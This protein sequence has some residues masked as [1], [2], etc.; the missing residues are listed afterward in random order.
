MVLFRSVLTVYS[1]EHE[2][3]WLPNNKAECAK[4]EM[5]DEIRDLIRDE[6]GYDSEDEVDDDFVVEMKWQSVRKPVFPP[7]SFKDVDYTPKPNE[8]LAEVYRETG[9]Q[10]IVKLA[11]IELTPENPDFPVGGW[12]V[13][14][15]MNEHICG[16]ALYYLDSENITSSNLSFRMQT[17]DL[18]ESDYYMVGQQ[19]FTWLEGVHGTSLQ[20]GDC[21]CL[22][23]YGQVETRQGR[24]LAFP[25]VL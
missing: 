8:R 18:S 11:S 25:N 15:Q 20:G 21:G 24:L 3:N 17:D 12:H 5:N 1:D 7:H 16:T 2:E 13:E 4:I 14:G 19:M 10:V 6:G 22:Q 9:L 23:N